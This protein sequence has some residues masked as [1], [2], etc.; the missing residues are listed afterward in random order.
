MLRFAGREYRTERGNE[1]GKHGVGRR[2]STL[3]H[4]LNRV[5]EVIPPD[6]ERPAREAVL[7]ATAFLQAFVI[8]VFGLID[9][10]AHLWAHESGVT[11]EGGRPFAPLGIGLTR[12]QADFRRTLPEDLQ[13]HLAEHDDW[14]GYL[15]NYRHSLAHRIPLYIPPFGL[16]QV[17]ADEF[18]RLNDAKLAALRAMDTNLWEQLDQ[19]Q[20][21]LGV[22]QPMMMHSFGEQAQPIVLH[23]QM[24]CDLLTVNQLAGRML[25][26]LEALSA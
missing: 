17:D 24:I 7:D 9:N 25:A 8:N 23:P 21:Q 18:Q 10:L 22:F 4:C 11:R 3:G 26:A 13:A 14:F 15:E 1:F 6:V 12:K 19:Q 5:F 20:K 2:L 16:T